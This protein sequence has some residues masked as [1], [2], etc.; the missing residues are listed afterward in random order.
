MKLVQKIKIKSKDIPI[1]W[2]DYFIFYDTK[3]NG[4]KLKSNFNRIALT[5]KNF[6]NY[7]INNFNSLPMF[8]RNENDFKS[9]LHNLS[10]IL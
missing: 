4:I 10:E 2:F 8:L 6:F 3:R 7:C 5:E 9:F 1:H